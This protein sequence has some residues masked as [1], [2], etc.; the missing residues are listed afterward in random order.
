MVNKSEGALDLIGVGDWRCD[1]A[2]R[3]V[4]SFGAVWSL[5]SSECE[6]GPVDICVSLCI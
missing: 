3:F 2:Q 1:V 4:A 5:S 6:D